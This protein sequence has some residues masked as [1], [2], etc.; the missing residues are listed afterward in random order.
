MQAH[1][2][3]LAV[4]IQFS[5]SPVHNTETFEVLFRPDRYYW[6]SEEHR[7]FA[8]CQHE[9]DAKLITAALNK[10]CDEGSGWV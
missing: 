6:R 4:M 7:R 1:C 8:V 9:K 10:W 5:Y 3:E 2:V